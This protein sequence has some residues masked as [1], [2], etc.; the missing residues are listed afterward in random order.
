[1]GGDMA[2]AQ[3]KM[4]TTTTGGLISWLLIMTVV[5]FLFYAYF[6][7]WGEDAKW[8]WKHLPAFRSRIILWMLF[9]LV[10][11]SIGSVGVGRFVSRGMGADIEEIKRRNIAARAKD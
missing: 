10:T 2:G 9:I 5:G 1:M 6:G 8:A 3:Q 7:S 4:K 11:T